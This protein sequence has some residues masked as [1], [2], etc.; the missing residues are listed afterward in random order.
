MNDPRFLARVE[1][2][3][4]R[5]RLEQS[6][7]I[8]RPVL[9][10]TVLGSGLASLDATVVN[11]ALPAIGKDLGAAVSGLQWVLTGYLITL[12]ALIL[13]GAL[14]AFVAWGRSRES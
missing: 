1:K 13:L 8:R 7:K 2:A 3:R 14:A 4:A 10:A 12:A 11:V 5:L 6:V 9:L